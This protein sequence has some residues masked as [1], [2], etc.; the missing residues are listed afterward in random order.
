[1][2]TFFVLRVRKFVPK[3]SFAKLTF[4]KSDFLDLVDYDFLDLAK[5]ATVNRFLILPPTL[6][7]P[8]LANAS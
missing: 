2:K 5:F 8:A 4:G 7:P 6:P 3:L 1:M